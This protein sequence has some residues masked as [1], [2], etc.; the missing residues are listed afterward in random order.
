MI[1]PTQDNPTLI[2]SAETKVGMDAGKIRFVRICIF[3]APKVFNNLILSSSTSLK[4]FK[5]DIIVTTTE[6]RRAIT[7]IAVMPLATYIKML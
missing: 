2:L 1:T 5:T 7:I 3:L 6:I 4:P